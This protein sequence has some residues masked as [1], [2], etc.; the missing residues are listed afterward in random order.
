[1]IHMAF[2]DGRPLVIIEGKVPDIWA[3]DGKLFT[4]G[5]SK[6]I[7]L[8]NRLQIAEVTQNKSRETSGK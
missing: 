3:Y 2:Y 1:M 6:E 4:A 5:W 8:D 7:C